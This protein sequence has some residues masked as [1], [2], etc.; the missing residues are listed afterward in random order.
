MSGR[1]DV[2]QR[3]RGRQGS[4][5]RVRLIAEGNYPVAIGGVTRWCDLLL[6]GLTGIDWEVLALG[7][8]G[9][10]RSR[11][12]V[13]IHYPFPVDPRGP[14]KVPEDGIRLIEEL[15]RQL[16]AQDADPRSLL[17]ALVEVRRCGALPR[18]PPVAGTETT[19][20]GVAGVGAEAIR[21]VLVDVA[22]SGLRGGPEP[23]SDAATRAATELLSSVV[24]AAT[25]PLDPV[26]VTLSATAGVAAVP[27]ALERLCNGTPLIVV[28]HGIYVGEAH[29]RTESSSFDDWTRWVVRSSAENLARAAYLAAS[30]VVGVSEANVASSQRLG[31][32]PAVCVCIPNGVDTPATPAPVTGSCAVGTVA[33]VDPFKGVDLFVEVAAMVADRFPQATFMHVGPTEPSQADYARRCWELAERAGLGTRLALLGAHRDPPSILGR[34]AVQVIPS[35]SEGLPFSLLEGMAAGR[36]IVATSVGGIPEAL[37]DAGL[38][39]GSGDL[40][41]LADSISTLLTDRQQARRLGRLAHTAVRE[42]YPLRYMLD[43][44]GELFDSM[45]TL[46]AVA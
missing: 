28:E 11:C 6:C 39:V 23:I 26:D 2:D 37:G 22:P 3:H 29:S 33:R 43:G 12:G 44:Y 18:V 13:R 1:H 36:P 41:A 14:A 34:F 15:A 27:G 46:G 16:F 42:L 9:R 17:G 32:D 40:G 45:Q 25:T 38:I 8:A 21:D 24:Q 35:R 30:A 7:V 20:T 10:R 31:A 5:R 4:G 19:A